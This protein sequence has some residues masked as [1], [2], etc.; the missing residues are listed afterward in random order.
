MYI[1]PTA[2]LVALSFFISLAKASSMADTLAAYGHPVSCKSLLVGSA[3]LL[4]GRNAHRLYLDPRAPVSETPVINGIIAYRDRHAAISFHAY[5]AG[6][7]CRVAVEE[8]FVLDDPC[9]T[10]REEIL[11]KWTYLG[12]LDDQ[13]IVLGDTKNGYPQVAYLS[14]AI[15]NK[16]ICLVH[17]HRDLGTA[18]L[19]GSS[20]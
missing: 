1:K 4:I 14:N 15:K 6:N 17:L 19:S 3:D 7:D 16:V 12:K 2:C 10:G 5:H 11:R 13:T 8:S 18:A 9:V 20:P